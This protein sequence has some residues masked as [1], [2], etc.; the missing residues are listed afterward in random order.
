VKLAWRAWL[1]GAV[2]LAL[3]IGGL[4]ITRRAEAPTPAASP[5]PV[6]SPSPQAAR[7]PQ[8]PPPLGRAELTE[9]AELAASRYAAG[10]AIPNT[11]LAGRRFILSLPFGCSGPVAD[12]AEVQSGWTLDE[13]G[14][15]LRAKVL[16]EELTETALMTAT[17]GGAQVEAAEGF[18]IDR[19][20][21]LAET[22]PAAASK[23]AVP[24]RQTL[25]LV[26]LYEPGAQRARRRGGRAYTAVQPV[27]AE[28]LD[29]SAGL[30]LRI[31]GRLAPIADGPP[32]G[33]WSESPAQRPSCLISARFERIAITDAS[34][35]RVL[36]EWND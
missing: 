25:A 9:A 10:E 5:T 28:P 16:P 6:A 35:A 23:D 3:A 19:P 26:E 11:V 27:G 7:L 4:L 17:A 13:D 32:I 8:P 30:R 12:L 2:F 18:W 33:C 14:R 21:R 29:L 1:A 34:G 24:D 22:C 15:T 36:A 20:W 31:E